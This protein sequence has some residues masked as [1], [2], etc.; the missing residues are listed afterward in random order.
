MA[1]D[2]SADERE[3]RGFISMTTRR[4]VFGSTANW[5]FDPPVSTPTLRMTALASSRMAWYWRSESV[6]CGATVIESPVWT[7]MASKFSIEH[8]MITLSAVSRMTSSSNSFHPSIDS[9]I[10]TSCVGDSERPL[11]TIRR[12]SA[13]VR[14]TPPPEPP[15]VKEGRTTSGRLISFAIASASASVRARA[16]RGTSAPISSMAF[17]KRSRSSARRIECSL[18]PIRSTLRFSRTPRSARAS[19]RLMAV[20]PPT[21]GR[22]ASGRSR[23]MI[24]SRKSGV[25]GSMYVASASSGSVMIVAG[26]ELTRMTRYPSRLSA[27]TAWVPE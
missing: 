16:D 15:I 14:A 2:A 1:L 27:R 6:I 8:T 19:A 10:R 22:I 20:C 7:P 25:S 13:A 11:W 23:S 24:R 4:P 17:L 18:A 9:S 3:T 12:K 21:V 5:M 26:F